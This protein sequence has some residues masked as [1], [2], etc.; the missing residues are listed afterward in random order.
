M[1][2]RREFFSSL[3]RP[4]GVALAETVPPPG[5]EVLRLA[6]TGGRVDARRVTIAAE[7]LTGAGDPLRLA[8]L[9]AL[10]LDQPVERDASGGALLDPA[11]MTLV[12]LVANAERTGIQG[13]RRRAAGPQPPPAAC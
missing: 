11:T 12:A 5:S 1:L 3:G 13:E 4:A 10:F 2:D 6:V 7:G 9:P 8:A